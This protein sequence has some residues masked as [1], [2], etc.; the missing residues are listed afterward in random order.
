MTK[1]ELARDQINNYIDECRKSGEDRLPTERELAGRL[2]FSRSTIVK[3]LSVLELEGQVYRRQGSGT[4]IGSNP[5]RS[6]IKNIGICFEGP[7]YQETEGHNAFVHAFSRLSEQLDVSV[8]YFESLRK[9]RD[10][11]ERLD[12]ILKTINSGLLDGIISIGRM[13]VCVVGELSEKVPVISVGMDLSPSRIHSVVYDLFRA[14]FKA[15]D[16]L[17]RHG[18]KKLLYV[19]DSL[20]HPI[21]IRQWSGF[22]SAMELHGLSYEKCTVFEGK[23]KGRIFKDELAEHLKGNEFTGIFARCNV[24]ANDVISVTR[25]MGKSIPGDYSVIGLGNI[26]KN[27]EANTALTVIDCQY[28][29]MCEI[30]LTSL[31]NKMYGKEDELLFGK[32]HICMIDPEVTEGESVGRC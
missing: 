13:P 6:K 27:N 19:T 12:R 14:G 20:N 29:K 9:Y 4:Y 24:M 22:R 15:A 31:H 23:A 11:S 2:K 10:E 7:L 32:S 16:Y 30:A 21:S 3:A 25:E 1:S 5:Y 18:H 17:I 26:L 8:Q 28:E